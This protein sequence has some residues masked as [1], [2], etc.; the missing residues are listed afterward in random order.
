MQGLSTVVMH[1]R[2]VLQQKHKTQW[3]KRQ[4][5]E[6]ARIGKENR[7]KLVPRILLTESIEGA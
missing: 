7:P 4:K 3:P 5:L 1:I 6:I 2:G